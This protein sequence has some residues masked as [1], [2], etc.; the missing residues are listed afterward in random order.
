MQ[1]EGARADT[2]TV[3][4]Q[5]TESGTRG[6][7]SK[8]YKDPTTSA[9]TLE[10]KL[11]LRVQRTFCLRISLDDGS[12][13]NIQSCL[14][15]SSSKLLQTA[16]GS[17]QTFLARFHNPDSVYNKIHTCVRIYFVFESN[18]SFPKSADSY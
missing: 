5:V 10:R 9:K 8:D 3:N 7:K 15:A 17:P 14:Y 2:L 1:G 11:T 18:S 12:R 6:I 16:V 4:G 13:S